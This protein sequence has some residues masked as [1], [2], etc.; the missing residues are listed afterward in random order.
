MLKKEE[1]E[2]IRDEHLRKWQ[3]SE[4]L[5][6]QRN[7]EK[8]KKELADINRQLG[9]NELFTRVQFILLLFWISNFPVFRPPASGRRG[10]RGPEDD[11]QSGMMKR[12]R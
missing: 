4:M 9:K 1:A 2:K 12:P 7:M 8:I 5:E 10:K 3:S 6:K 11:E